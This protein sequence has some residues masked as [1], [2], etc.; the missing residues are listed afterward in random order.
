MK[1][2]PNENNEKMNENNEK[3]NEKFGRVDFQLAL[4][5]ESI[6]F[7]SKINESNMNQIDTIIEH[8]ISYTFYTIWYYYTC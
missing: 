4:Q 1:S 2:V 7:D 8:M 3:V 5:L 6:L